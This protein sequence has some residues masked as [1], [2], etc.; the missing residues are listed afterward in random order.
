MSTRGGPVEGVWQQWYL[1]LKCY[2]SFIAHC[3]SLAGT[4]LC[5]RAARI[6]TTEGSPKLSKFIRTLKDDPAEAPLVSEIY[7]MKHI[8]F[9]WISHLFP[10][11]PLLLPPLCP[12]GLWHK[13]L[14]VPTHTFC[15]PSPQFWKASSPLG[16]T[17]PQRK[18][19]IFVLFP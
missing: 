9:H 19:E 8:I 16:N 6:S 3:S 13:F 4:G 17:N 1:S 12:S 11:L 2:S 15:V 18:S 7:G 14:K 10:S 5:S